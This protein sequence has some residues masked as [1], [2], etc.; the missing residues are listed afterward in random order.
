MDK[1]DR[2][3]MPRTRKKSSIIDVI[4]LGNTLDIKNKST[5]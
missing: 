1:L 5:R 3:S 4:D 2:A